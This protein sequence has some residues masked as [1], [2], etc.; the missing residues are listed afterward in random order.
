MTGIAK[1]SR[2]DVTSVIHTNT[3]MRNSV[4]PGARMFRIVTMKLRPAAIEAIPRICRPK[5]QKSMPWPGEYAF[6]RERSR[7]RTS[8]RPAR[9]ARPEKM[10]AG[11]E[12]RVHE[13]A[14][15]QEHPVAEG[16]QAR[17][18][19]VAGADHQ[20]NHQVEEGGR[21]SA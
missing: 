1:M 5:A 9:P 11:E 12:A 17:E 21:S 19:D 10:S 13:E 2:N 8:R 16:V 20:R 4:M 15:A 18:G 3:G 14:A 7:S 6:E